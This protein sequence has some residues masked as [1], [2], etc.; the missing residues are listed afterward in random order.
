MGV[1]AAAIAALGLASAAYQ[2]V[3]EARD[4]RRYPPPGRLVDVGGY[5]LHIVC[6]GQGSP[7]VVVIPALGASTQEWVE[8]QRRLAQ[9]TTVCVYD[10]AGLGWSESPPK[11]RTALRMAQELHA[12]L[13]GADIE[14]PYVLAGHSLGGLMARV[15]I[16]LY[17]GEVAGLAL[18][19]PSHPKMGERLPRSH[20]THSPSGRMLYVALE[21][22]RPLGIQRLSRDLA[23]RRADI[24]PWARKRRADESELLALNAICRQTGEMTGDL[25]NLP[26]AVLTA[27]EFGRQDRPRARYQSWL[28]LQ[29]ELATLSANSTHVVAEHGGHHLNRDNP[30]LVV[31]VVADLVKRVRS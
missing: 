5:R 11:H 14:S 26:L 24:I 27:S 9:E 23:L 25:G 7:A 6:A 15:F 30:E 29:D 19:D 2:T 12:L 10:R 31:E 8:V 16:H 4:R 20:M 17:P 21:R 3:G 1:F 28:V 18:I 22:A 13:H